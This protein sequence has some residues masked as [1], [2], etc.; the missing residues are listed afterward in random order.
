MITVPTSANA[1]GGSSR[2]S[3]KNAKLIGG[4]VGSIGG[5]I[6]IGL[7]VALFLFLKKRKKITNQSP[8]FN[9]NTSGES[10]S[11]RDKSGFKKLFGAKS[12]AVGDVSGVHDFEKQDRVLTSYPGDENEDNDDFEYRGVSNNNNLG[13]VFKS[14][15][16][17]NS[18]GQNTAAAGSLNHT[19]MNSIGHQLDTPYEA[20]EYQDAQESDPFASHNRLN[21]DGTD[22]FS[23]SDYD[24]EED[25]LPPVDRGN[26]FGNDIHSNNSRSRFHEEIF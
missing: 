3:E 10:D 18:S 8:D 4:L 6:V 21:S 9:E 12:A 19:R 15:T 20:H 11:F 14:S 24:L 13:G 17:T 1:D 23:P 26:I 2:V 25:E 22:H 7:L 16:A 5:T